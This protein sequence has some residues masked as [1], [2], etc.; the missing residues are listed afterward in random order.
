MQLICHLITSPSGS[1]PEGPIVTLRRCDHAGPAGY[2]RV[3]SGGRSFCG[4]GRACPLSG[5]RPS[6]GNLGSFR[7]FHSGPVRQRRAVRRV[8]ASQMSPC[9]SVT[10][11]RGSSVGHGSIP[12]LFSELSRIRGRVYTVLRLLSHRRASSFLGARCLARIS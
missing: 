4:L 1:P 2:I 6:R 12:W 7:C 8:Q 10:C 9:C 5:R 11:V 3:P